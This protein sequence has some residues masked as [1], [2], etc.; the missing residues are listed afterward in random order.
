MLHDTRLFLLLFALLTFHD[1][2]DCCFIVVET[3]EFRSNAELNERKEKY[4]R[5]TTDNFR[6]PERDPSFLS[7]TNFVCVCQSLFTFRYV[8]PC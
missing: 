3:D 4:F 5:A 8:S 2:Y 7:H 6:H 1:S